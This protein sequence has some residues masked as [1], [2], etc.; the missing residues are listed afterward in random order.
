MSEVVKFPPERPHTMP[1]CGTGG[2]KTQ[3]PGGMTT[4]S[5]VAS[6]TGGIGAGN[7]IKTDNG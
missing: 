1:V 2:L 5:C 4:V 7:L 6:A 3:V